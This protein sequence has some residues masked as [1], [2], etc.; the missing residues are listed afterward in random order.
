MLNLDNVK[1]N[2]LANFSNWLKVNYHPLT[3]Y[4]HST[5]RSTEYIIDNCIVIESNSDKTL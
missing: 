5:K 3:F 1:H 4:Q 2:R